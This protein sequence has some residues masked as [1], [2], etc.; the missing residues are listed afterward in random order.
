MLTLL[1]NKKNVTLGRG[2]RLVCST[3]SS[4]L[5]HRLDK[6]VFNPNP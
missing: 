1:S 6:P 3:L 2:R 5:S 4:V